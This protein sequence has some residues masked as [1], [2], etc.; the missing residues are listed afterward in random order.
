MWRHSGERL[1]IFI[2]ANENMTNGSFHEMF[3]G[4]NLHMRKAVTHRHPDPWWQ[5]TAS[6]QKGDILGKWPIDGV[7][8]TPSLPIE[9]STWLSFMP[10][11]GD[12][13]FAVINID[14]KALVGDDLLK[15][16]RLQAQQLSCA[17]PV[18]VLEYNNRLAE[19]MT[20]HSVLSR[21][22]HQYSARDGNFMPDERA[23]LESL[24]CV[25]AEGMVH[26]EK[27]CRK[28]AMGNVDYSPEVD[29]AK[30]KH[31]LWKEVVKKQAGC[32]VS[33]AMIKRK[34]RQCGIQCPLS[35]TLAQAKEWFQAADKEYN[36]MK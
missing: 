9:A 35:V 17:I 14:S 36:S 3:M 22:H 5:H 18:A 6:Y 33:A 4:P 8:V 27:R 31:W 30:K 7:Y 26:A 1:V 32:P 19:Y 11:L 16:V 2:D 24:D 34:A 15:I 10:H 29:L 21:L 20:R 28:L 13:R 12:H 23:Q 25:Q